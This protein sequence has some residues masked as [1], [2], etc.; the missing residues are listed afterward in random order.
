MSKNSCIINRWKTI[1]GRL[2]RDF[3]PTFF[4]LFSKFFQK[5][6]SKDQIL[7]L[8]TIWTK[9]EETFKISHNEVSKSNNRFPLHFSEKN[10]ELKH[11]LETFIMIIYHFIIR[12]NEKPA[13][14]TFKNKLSC[15]LF[16]HK[17]LYILSITVLFHQCFIKFQILSLDCF[18]LFFSISLTFYPSQTFFI[19]KSLLA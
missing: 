18:V 8:W 1:L 16:T 9:I 4:Q 19:P 12:T 10:Y 3:F 15:L 7:H 14:S 6:F 17:P 2:F 5:F 13:Y 11:L